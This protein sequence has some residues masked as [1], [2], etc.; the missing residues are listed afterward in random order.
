MKDPVI[1]IIRTAS[2]RVLGVMNHELTDVAVIALLDAA[3]RILR[4][5]SPGMSPADAC[6]ELSRV[7]M[8][9]ASDEAVAEETKHAQQS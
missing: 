8:D 2:D 4:A 7:I 1:Q 3:V 5:E 6:V 9:I